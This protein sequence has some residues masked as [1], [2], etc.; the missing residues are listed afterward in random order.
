M[1]EAG[2]FLLAAATLAL[3][4]ALTR[5]FALAHGYHFAFLSIGIALLGLGAGGTFLSLRQTP[6]EST[7]AGV[8]S[9]AFAITT[10]G[11]YLLSNAVPF[12]MYRIAWERTQ[13]LYLLV[14]YLALAAPFFCSGLAI[15][16]SLR[17]ARGSPRVYAMN[18]IGSATGTLLALLSLSLVGGAGTV[19]LS[20]AGGGL[21]A[22]A[23]A[24][25]GNLQRM[26]IKLAGIGCALSA[27]LLAALSPPWIEVRLSPYRP[28]SQA[29]QL[30]QANLVYTRWSAFSRVDVVQS[31]AIH[32]A[33]GLSLDY[34]G[35][36]PDQFGL[37]ADANARAAIIRDA[38]ESLAGWADHL[39]V[40]LAY[41]LRP[42]AHT[43]V[44]APGGGLDVAVARALG[45]GPIVAVSPDRLVVD[46]ASR[47]GGELYTDGQVQVIISSP[48][49]FVRQYKARNQPPFD[50]IVLSLSDAQRTVVSGGYAL[51]ED[52]RYTLQAVADYLKL[53]RP[54]GWLVVHR[55]LQTPPSESLRAWA[56]AAQALEQAGGKP[57]R[58]MAAIRSWSTMLIM[59]KQGEITAQEKATIRSF[60]TSRHFDLV[61]LPHMQPEE[62]NHYNVYPGAPYAKAVQKLLTASGR[63]SF[64][65]HQR[66]DLRPP[67]DN[68]PFF[69]HFFTWRQLPELRQS[70]GRTWQPFGG[71]GYLVLIALLL[72]AVLS[73]AALTLLPAAAHRRLGKGH[74]PRITTLAYF[75]CL[76]FAYLGVEIP[77]IQRLS[78][79]LERPTL[80]F[81]VVV[82]TLLIASGT[83]SLLTPAK[84]ERWAPF[85]V[86]GAIALTIPSLSILDEMGLGW[87]LTARMTATAVALAPLGLSMGMP[88]TVGIKVLGTHSPDLIPW[89]WGVNGGTSV[90]ASVL[91]AL[92][93]LSWGFNAVILIAG[94]A[95]LAAGALLL[96]IHRHI[97]T[98]KITAT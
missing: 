23:F 18:L 1:I 63:A 67:T 11:G 49:S 41:H 44:L 85:A 64:Y 50:L 61:Y 25:Q 76:G 94:A 69:F 68:R 13:V 24:R 15:G 4:I 10:V 57:A 62:A 12:D 31:P 9:L 52:Y 93:A 51:T 17:L 38:P 92:I 22:L 19:M 5:V 75:G 32:V 95:Y 56:L 35:P 39:P 29:L 42:Y 16:A 21:A 20:A 3:E 46:A 54:E 78:L 98:A 86:A 48:R 65:R 66:Y 28:L 71:G 55:W 43:L 89:A 80:S 45:A 82:A 34:A 70:L 26:A 33:P 8:S 36:I 2:T 81:A 96:S 58:Q 84:I 14:Y 40:A 88:F 73:S 83:G 87:S 30:P 77:L 79:L 91:A 37:Y 90:I 6:A 97:Y 60:C 59:V 47:Y 7:L 53:L 74:L 27:S 72:I